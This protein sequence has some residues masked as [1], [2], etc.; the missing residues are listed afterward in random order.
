MAVTPLH[1]ICHYWPVID[2]CI[3]EQTYYNRV[4]LKFQEMPVCVYNRLYTKYT[5]TLVVILWML[6]SFEINTFCP[7]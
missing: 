7:N 2:L 4:V 6:A 3:R 1:E 5:H